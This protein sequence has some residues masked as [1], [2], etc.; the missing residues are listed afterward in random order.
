MLM[1][2]STQKWKVKTWEKLSIN[3]N[4]KKADFRKRKK[5]LLEIKSGIFY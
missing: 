5:I 1:Y 3:T 2:K 4:Q